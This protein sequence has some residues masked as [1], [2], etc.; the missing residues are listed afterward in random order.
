[1]VTSPGSIL[2]TGATGFIGKRLAQRLI[3]DGFFVRCMVRQTASA[4]PDGTEIVR[5]DLLAP[6]TLDKVLAG[7]CPSGKEQ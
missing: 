4:V 1:M 7:I 2:I 6:A 3:K 5:G